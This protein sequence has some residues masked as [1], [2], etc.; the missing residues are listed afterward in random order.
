[1]AESKRS[2][3]AT[4][5]PITRHPLFPAIV[6]LWFGALAGLG[7]VVVSSSTIEGIVLAL[8]ID[9]VIPMAAPP[10][11]TTMR[12]LLALAM[13]GLGAAIGGVIARRIAGTAA[14]RIG[15]AEVETVAEEQAAPTARRRRALAIEP[16]A[17][18]VVAEAAPVPGEA[19]HA[20]IL[21][22]ADFEID[23]FDE[24]PDAYAPFRRQAE[25]VAA[26]SDT[27]PEVVGEAGGE[28][29]RETFEAGIDEE[30]NLPAW[31]EAEPTWYESTDR[32]AT[33]DNAAERGVFITPPGAQIFQ[34]ELDAAE[35]AG[36][37]TAEAPAGA[38]LFEAYSRELSPRH[39]APQNDTAAEGAL[40]DAGNDA[41]ND[42]GN[43]TPGFTLLPRLPEGDWNAPEAVGLQPEQESGQEHADDVWTGAVPPFVAPLIETAPAAEAAPFVPAFVNAA[44]P[45]SEAA[46]APLPE[47]PAENSVEYAP[48]AVRSAAERIVDADLGTLSQVELLERLALAME[49]RREDARLAAEQAAADAQARSMAPVA[50]LTAPFAPP[51]AA[52]VIG[53]PEVDEAPTWPAP[54]PEALRPIALDPI[55]DS[56]A[57]LPEFLPP[58][59]I[60]LTPPHDAEH[61]TETGFDAPAPIPFPTSPF[62]AEPDEEEDDSVL[63]QGYSSLLNLSRHAAV[64]KPFLQFG[65]L[66][67]AGDEMAHATPALSGDEADHAEDDHD[68]HDRREATPFGRPVLMPDPVGEAPPEPEERPFDAPRNDPDATER[69]LRAAL[70]TLQRMSGAA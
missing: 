69:A 11:G 55:E 48:F 67:E 25:P 15:A 45:V 17:S 64:R 34:A 26:V 38:R 39:D 56:A 23:S 46:D 43:A 60:G 44:E 6:A 16:D 59:H 54:V 22:V 47:A 32:A 12:I 63:Q 53:Q 20:R 29:G 28:T 19:D 7:S 31:L 42:S 13:T 51:F 14:E 21:N 58:R 30:D 70:A 66:D 37:Q 4:D 27:T 50:P 10:L 18:P 52:P 40:N 33:P 36:A 62:S 8:G 57:S 9:K 3:G 65:D 61:D 5:Q 68:G 49:R 24:A 41:G 35:R 1:M 2:V